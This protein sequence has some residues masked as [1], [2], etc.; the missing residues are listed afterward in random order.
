[1]ES[2]NHIGSTVHADRGHVGRTDMRGFV[3]G[4]GSGKVKWLAESIA[5]IGLLEPVSWDAVNIDC[6]LTRGVDGA[7]CRSM[8]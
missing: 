6:H 3:L 7:H 8:C 1:M 4:Y 2:R 5:E